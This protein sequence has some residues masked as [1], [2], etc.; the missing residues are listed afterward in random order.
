MKL[1]CVLLAVGYWLSV[2]LAQSL[3]TTIYL[4]DSLSRCVCP[5]VVLCD[6]PLGRIYVGTADGLVGVV[7]AATRQKLAWVQLS[8]SVIALERSAPGDRIYAL[9]G[10]DTLYTVDA[11]TN[12]VWAKTPVGIG[13]RALCI[14]S[15]R[16]KLFC[17][18]SGSSVVHVIDGS[19]G[20]IIAVVPVPQLPMALC[21]DPVHAKV[22][23]VC[24]GDGRIAVIDAVGDSMVQSIEAY[25]FG[26]AICL[27]SACS[28]AYIGY[29]NSRLVSVVDTDSDSVVATVSCPTDVN[30]LCYNSVDNRVICSSSDWSVFIIDCGQNAVRT[31]L[32]LP[33]L[34]LHVTYSA[35]NDRAYCSL[36]FGGVAVLDCRLERITTVLE[37]AREATAAVPEESSGT[38]WVGTYHGYDLI[39]IDSRGDSILAWV[40]LGCHPD[41]LVYSDAS[42]KLYVACHAGICAWVS[43]IDGETNELLRQ[44][45]TNRWSA[46][47][48]LN[49]VAN[50]VYVYSP[51][52]SC[53]EVIDCCSDSVRT[54]IAVPGEQ[55]GAL[56][57]SPEGG[58]VYCTNF[59]G[60]ALTVVD[61]SADSVRLTYHLQYP[62]GPREMGYCRTGKRLFVKCYYCWPSQGL[63]SVIAV[64]CSTDSIIAGIPTRLGS[65]GPLCYNPVNNIMYVSDCINNNIALVDCQ[66]NRV[67]R[68]VGV[69]NPGGMCC[70]SIDN[71]IFVTRRY[72]GQVWIIDGQTNQVDWLNLSCFMMG[73]VFYNPQG[74]TVY[75]AC[76][77]VAVLDAP[78]HSLR[79][80]VPAAMSID[81]DNPAFALNRDGQRVYALNTYQSSVLVFQDSIRV[82][83]READTATAP[84]AAPTIVRGVLFLGPSA[85]S[86][87]PAAALL[88]ISGRKVM[89]LHPGR[90]DVSRFGAGVY[91]VRDL[92]SGSSGRGE[93]RKVVIAR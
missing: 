29:A 89:E 7:D 40:P 4:P 21:F 74:Q 93:M 47:T 64:D 68:Y 51:W 38:V 91:F 80:R 71:K 81:V 48:C 35:A 85:V 70:D 61:C 55:D 24:A 45:K 76:D 60:Y 17:A 73:D 1:S 65:E 23:C 10:R 34:P 15:V 30:S 54:T 49:A 87:Q 27:N 58:R 22:F 75:L 39:G 88:D 92:G 59:Q 26:L 63:D 46:F 20:A 82:G 67:A 43:V 41:A 31:R 37:T 32:S 83:L 19:T 90:N 2:A 84:P 52:G 79:A 18:E 53:L 25:R 5:T 66:T 78:T 36:D 72:G 3:E 62:I 77:D 11:G 86:G 8:G 12:S 57:C 6:P 14:D 9:T 69:M 44:I 16:N 42:R 33:N 50:K 13:A 56:C 28:R